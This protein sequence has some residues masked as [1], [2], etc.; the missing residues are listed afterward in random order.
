MSFSFYFFPL[1]FFL[2]TAMDIVTEEMPKPISSVFE[3]T[4]KDLSLG[5]DTKEDLKR[6][7]EFFGKQ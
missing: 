5:I 7:L 2:F 6:A 4:K 3:V 1:F